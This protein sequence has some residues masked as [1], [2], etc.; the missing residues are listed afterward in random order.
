[1]VIH[2]LSAIIILAIYA[3][4][5]IKMAAA[6]AQY[7]F[8]FR[9]YW[10]CCLQKAKLYQQAKFR[11]HISIHGLNITTF[12][13]EK[14][15]SAIFKF[16]FRFQIPPLHRNRRVILRQAAEFRPNRTTQCGNITSYRFFKM[17][18][19]DAQNYFRFRICWCHCFQKVKIY[20]Q[21]KFCRHISI[22]GWYIITSGL[23]K[24]TSAI[25]EYH[26]RFFYLDHFAII[27]VLFC[28]R[29]LNFVQIV[30]PTAV[31]W[32]HIDFATWRRRRSILLPVSY[33]SAFRR[34]KCRR[35]ISIHGWDITTSGL[36]KQTSAILEFYF[37]F[38]SRPF[39]CN[40][41]VILH[42]AAE[43]CPNR[44]TQRSNMTSYRFS[45]W[46]SSA[47]LYLLWGNGRLPTKC[48]S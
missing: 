39:R 46:R 25:L 31:I 32:H 27:D 37:R 7:Y 21:T 11:P 43:F 3:Y 17:A 44:T 29:L 24:Q 13:L 12:G 40:R 23:E 15:T 42:Q 6:A 19:A 33:V 45:R 18:A 47:M 16:Y 26:F 28:I 36:E 41:R 2:E 4:R 14:Q 34:S 10:C 22:L 9:A 20:Q 8:R 38:R 35:H 30:Q 5:Q 48:T 1:M